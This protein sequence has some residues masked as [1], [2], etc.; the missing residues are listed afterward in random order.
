MKK[1]YILF[2]LTGALFS[3][4]S[5]FLEKP[6]LTS[7]ESSGYLASEE[8]L[9]SYV[10][11]L[12]T[13]LPVL[14]T[15]GMGMYGEEKNS[16]N[17]LAQN[18]ERRLNGELQESNGGSKDWEKG[19]KGLRDAN[20]C[21]QN[22]AVP[23]MDE[24]DKIL[25]LKGEAYFFRAYWHF[26]L[27]T[28]FGSIPLMEEL[29]D[30]NATVQGLQVPATDRGGVAKYIL[31][32]LEMAKELLF[33]RS[34][35]KGL[36]ISKEAAIILAMRVALYEGSW[37]KYHN[38][39]A[40]AAQ[41]NNSIE[42][43]NTVITLGDEL[44]TKDLQL[45]TKESDPFHAADGGEAFAHLFNQYDL[46]DISEA[47][48][49]KKY[50]ISGGLTH[51]LSSLLSQGT[52]DNTGPAG[53]SQSLVDN[54]LYATGLPIDP[55]EE[56]FQDFN[57]TFEGRDPRLLQTVMHS[58]CRFKADSDSKPM[59][60]VVWTEDNKDE[61]VPPYLLAGDNQRSITG[62]HIRLGLDPKFNKDKK[63]GET[64]LPI[65][66][67]AEALLAYAEAAAELGNGTC[68]AAILNK[69]LKP[70][71]ERVGVTYVE[72]TLADPNYPAHSDNYTLTPVL[73]EIRRERRS[74]LALQGF[75][76]D[77][78]MR[79][80]AGK[81]IQNQRGK[82]AYL[83]KESILYRAFSAEK[84]EELSKITLTVDNWM[85]PLAEWLPAGYQ[86]NPDRDYLLPIPLNE[87]NLNEQLSQNPGWRTSN[88]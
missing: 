59:N 21:I 9:T 68:D 17:I 19:Y 71:R 37:E 85:D 35:Y 83:G 33:P 80:R 29:W 30:K 22:Y 75:R 76:L 16:D 20:Y 39:T 87:I 5:D 62:Y 40:F 45:N 64:A 13:G 25:S 78:L 26:Y 84:A 49:W 43:F 67:Y 34:R 38:G 69:T 63:G 72:P 42:F 65:I 77:D 7:P 3:A 11:F 56:K 46:S 48:F 31:K 12:Y 53:L 28:R 60:V 61:V 81:L 57:R 24:T 66:R 74:E 6:P 10:D 15:Y 70:L 41:A 14:E 36:R 2:I 4:C 47:V 55:S 79:W 44:F 54:Y 8:H 18:Y 50:S 32:D 1:L 82:G 88:N 52:V 86:F 27:L 23:P 58:D 73:Q 51:G